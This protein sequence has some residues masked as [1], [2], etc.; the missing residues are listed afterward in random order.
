MNF[1]YRSSISVRASYCR[2]YPFRLFRLGA[3]FRGTIFGVMTFETTGAGA[4]WPPEFLLGVAFF[5]VIFCRR[6]RSNLGFPAFLNGF[7]GGSLRG[8]FRHN[9]P[10][11]RSF[12][13]GHFRRDDRFGYLG[14]LRRNA[15]R[16]PFRVPLFCVFV[17]IS[18]GGSRIRRNNF[19]RF[20]AGLGLDD[21]FTLLPCT[22][23]AELAPL[24]LSALLITIKLQGRPRKRLFQSQFPSERGD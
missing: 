18:L 11:G 22:F 9:A 19:R 24:I 10:L 1:Q 16:L 3:G 14:R 6:R 21:P 15:L 17:E 20:A 23:F 2:P 8:P 4:I 13:S 12:G 7:A 5:G